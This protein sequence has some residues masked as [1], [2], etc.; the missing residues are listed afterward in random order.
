VI[1]RRCAERN[2][3][4]Y[5]VKTTNEKDQEEECEEG[6]NA[7]SADDRLGWG[8]GEASSSQMS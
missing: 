6:C 4:I 8:E 2:G 3:T 1:Y 7:P 5:G